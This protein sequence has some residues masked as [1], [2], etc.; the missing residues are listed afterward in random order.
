MEPNYG[1]LYR[2]LFFLVMLG[3]EYSPQIFLTKLALLW[4]YY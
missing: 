2:V 1:E 4:R 3:I